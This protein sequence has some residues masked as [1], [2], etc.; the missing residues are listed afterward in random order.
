MRAAALAASE[1]AMQQLMCMST[2]RLH[3]RLFRKSMHLIHLAHETIGCLS[4][5]C[6]SAN[7]RIAIKRYS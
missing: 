5:T 1:K 7:V 3:K 2:T 4:E 6:A